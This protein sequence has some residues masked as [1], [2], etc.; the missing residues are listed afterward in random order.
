MKY[1]ALLLLCLAA[2]RSLAY[3][4]DAAV[5]APEVQHPAD[6][7]PVR[8]ARHTD[9][10]LVEVRPLDDP[11]NPYRGQYTDYDRWFHAH[12]VPEVTEEEQKHFGG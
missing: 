12:Y 7:P 4:A 10:R 11:A 5:P 2:L 1:L 8:L 3:A 6:P 9:G